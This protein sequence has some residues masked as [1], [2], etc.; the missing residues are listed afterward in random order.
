MKILITGHRGFIGTWLYNSLSKRGDVELYGVDRTDG[1]DLLDQDTYQHFDAFGPDIII[2]LAALVG[3][4]FGEDDM[5]KTVDQNVTVT[6]NVANKAL[7]I[8]ARIVYA[9]SSEV[10]GDQG[11]AICHETSPTYVPH[12][13]YGLTKKFGEDVLKLYNPKGLQIIRLS[14]P[15]GP[16]LPH[17][18]GRAAI[19]N[20]LW[21]AHTGQ[22]IITHKG[23]TRCWCWVGD[24]I[25]GIEKVIFNGEQ[26]E[27][28][29]DSLIYPGKG[30][31]NVGRDDNETTM[32]QIAINACEIAGGDESNINLVDPPVNQTA[33][34]RLA[35]DKLEA[36]GWSPTV[37]VYEGMQKTFQEMKRMGQI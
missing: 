33:I 37:E 30:I 10:Y 17:G 32:Y 22:P 1:L 14:M 26:M 23:A 20:M 34:K 29:N 15:F 13:L 36:L 16:G 3:R 5:K 21:Q 18:R 25:A 4:K 31:Y 6:S 7:E 28:S 27:S 35:T 9:S 11:E 24:T 12:N 2:H 19:I 8:G